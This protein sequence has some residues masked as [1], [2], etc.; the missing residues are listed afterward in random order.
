MS[1]LL[2]ALT[3]PVVA[4]EP[5]TAG[6]TNQTKIDPRVEARSISIPDAEKQLIGKPNVVILD[7]RTEQE[8]EAGHLAGAIN[9]NSRATNFVERLHQLDRNKTYLVHSAG[10]GS[11]VTKTLEIFDGIGFTNWV[12]LAGGF[13]AWTNAARPIVK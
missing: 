7:V 11:R 1:I 9:V 8:F 3:F 2:P 6:A 12:N 13:S 4:A 10:G 5:A